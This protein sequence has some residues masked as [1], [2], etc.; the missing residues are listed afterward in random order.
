[1]LLIQKEFKLFHQKQ[2]KLHSEYFFCLFVFFFNKKRLAAKVDTVTSDDRKFNTV[3]H[4]ATNKMKH[5]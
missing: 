5:F 3:G 2:A 1:M 4:G